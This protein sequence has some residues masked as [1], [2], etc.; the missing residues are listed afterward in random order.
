MTP[1]LYAWIIAGACF[2]AFTAT[3]IPLVLYLLTGWRVRR[4]KLLSYLNQDALAVYYNQFPWTHSTEPDLQ[5][6][7]KD[8]FNF[9]YGR[10]HYIV[11]TALLSC[12]SG[13]AA[14]LV[15]RSVQAWFKVA[16]GAVAAPKI[17][18]SALLGAF[19]WAVSDELNRI[20][21]RDIAPVDVY[22]W[23]FR[24]LIAIPFGFAAAAI[25]KEDAGVPLAFFLGA[26]PTQTLFTFA[27]RI[28]TQKLALGDQQ[29]DS[30]LELEKLQSIGRSNAER[31]QDEGIGTISTLA[32]ADP[33]DLTIRTNFDFNYVL[34]CMS[35]ALLWVYFEDKTRSLYALSL[36]GAQELSGLVDA[37]EGID[38]PLKAGATLTSDQ[39]KA[40]AT[41]HEASEV[42][43][44]S[45]E[46]LCTTLEEVSDDPY[47]DFIRKVWH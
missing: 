40:A 14:V 2:I 10:R 42:L 22:G 20:R 1:A 21:R 19:L 43:K 31:Y 11:P 7:F 30:T 3:V 17:A 25:L 47:T 15:A 44:M 45:E 13:G 33:V 5:K 38:F 35:Q 23:G 27:R 39:A 41:L 16:P 9:L 26:F 28:A 24:I 18:V 36:R 32:W 6:R 34:D 8:Q 4:D 46:A 37:L 29:S 12:V